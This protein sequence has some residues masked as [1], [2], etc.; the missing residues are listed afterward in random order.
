LRFGDAVAYLEDLEADTGTTPEPLR[1][2]PELLTYLEPTLEAFHL[3][4]GA[5]NYGQGFPQPLAI[6]D[7]LALAPRYESGDH[8]RFLRAMRELDALFLEDYATTHRPP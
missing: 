4:S 8:L 1:E 3:L 6:A 2:R 5:R 7:I